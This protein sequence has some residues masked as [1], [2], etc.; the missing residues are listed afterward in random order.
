MTDPVKKEKQETAE[1]AAAPAAP[2]PLKIAEPVPWDGSINWKMS[3][4]FDSHADEIE[5]L[6]TPGIVF[7]KPPRSSHVRDAN[8]QVYG[9]HDLPMYDTGL[10]YLPNSRETNYLRSVR[11][12]AL[13]NGVKLN[14]VLAQ[15]CGGIIFSAQLLNTLPM[16]GYHTAL[17]IFVQQSA[18]EAFVAYA[19][20]TGIWIKG[21]RAVVKMV[22]TPT[23]PLSNKY[24]S[25]LRQ[26]Y[27]RCLAIENAK[28]DMLD[29]LRELLYDCLA[30]RD[31][32]E[33]CEEDFKESSGTI[34]IRFHGLKNSVVA[35]GFL[36]KHPAFKGCRFRFATDPCA[37]MPPP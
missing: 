5:A 3:R 16:N 6:S 15:V 19:N 25:L 33:A 28:P 32:I 18:A 21:M 30:C 8:N 22:N 31:F 29:K 11:I 14:E 10:R 12:G 27:S 20:E 26:G 23:Y 1:K 9:I 7:D 17:I 34:Q 24:E 35:H 2:S 4:L 37:R 36:T 13:P